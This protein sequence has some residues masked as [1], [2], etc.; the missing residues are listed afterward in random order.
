M[1]QV[2]IVGWTPDSKLMYVASN[3]GRDKSALF[4]FDPKTAKEG[5]LIYENPN[6]DIDRSAGRVRAR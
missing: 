4:E 1:K 3:R 5:K 6:V 2:D